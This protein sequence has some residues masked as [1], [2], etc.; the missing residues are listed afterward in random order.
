VAGQADET[1]G[2]VYRVSPTVTNESLNALFAASWPEHRWRDYTTVLHHSLAYICAYQ[3]ARLI[4]FLN[5]AWDGGIHAFLL[6]TTVQPDLRR[7][8]IG[9]ELVARAAEVARDR[10]IEWLHV[11]YAPH[12]GG[13]YR[14][15]G[16]RHT[17]AALLHLADV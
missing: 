2:I 9:R 12:L 7:R 15:C 5:V 4:G 13:F 3:G 8:G 10:G 1:V 6:D 17:D 11:D 14:C 16:F